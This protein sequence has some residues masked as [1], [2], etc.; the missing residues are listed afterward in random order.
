MQ[1]LDNEPSLDIR[2]NINIKFLIFTLLN[3]C[4]PRYANF[5]VVE[6]LR[7]GL[8][9]SCLKKYIFELYPTSSYLQAKL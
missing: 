4:I 9:K 7:S 8:Q 5:P 1:Y 6:H 2:N 3:L